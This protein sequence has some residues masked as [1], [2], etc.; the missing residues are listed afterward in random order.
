[1]TS[2]VTASGPEPIC[3]FLFTRWSPAPS[4]GPSSAR[5]ARL[6]LGTWW[7]RRTQRGTS[8]SLRPAAARPHTSLGKGWEGASTFVCFAGWLLWCPVW[9]GDESRSCRRESERPLV[10]GTSDLQTVGKCLCQRSEQR[11]G[12]YERMLINRQHFRK[13]QM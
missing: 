1:M 2:Q 7:A 8:P 4:D 11:R 6:W 9:Q 10:R 12:T 5:C 3:P 13:K